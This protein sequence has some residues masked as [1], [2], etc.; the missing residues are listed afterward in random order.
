M[1]SAAFSAVQCAHPLPKYC[2]EKGM[3]IVRS[4]ERWGCKQTDIFVQLL[5]N[6]FNRLLLRH[7]IALRSE[8]DMR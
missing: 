6:I 4:L 5:E 2:T 1:F 8:S 7:P 3:P